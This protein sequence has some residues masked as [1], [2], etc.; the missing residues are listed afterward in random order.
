MSIEGNCTIFPVFQDLKVL[1]GFL[2]ERLYSFPSREEIIHP[3]PQKTVTVFHKEV[4]YLFF[5]TNFN[6][7]ALGLTSNKTTYT[8]N[9]KQICL[10]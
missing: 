2:K 10:L 5:V 8:M 1:K 9:W 3:L 6:R 7:L 4:C